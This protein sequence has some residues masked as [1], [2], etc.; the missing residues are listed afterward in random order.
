MTP[1]STTDGT[2]FI[3][4]RKD[5][6]DGLALGRSVGRKMR[7]GFMGP[8]LWIPSLCKRATTDPD[9][10]G[11]NGRGYYDDEGD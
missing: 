1:V 11:E 10:V 9:L 7:L 3:V 6:P 5:L 8:T 4:S 2:S